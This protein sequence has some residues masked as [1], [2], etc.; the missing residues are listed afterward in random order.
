MSANQ[1]PSGG[2]VD[3][4]EAARELLGSGADAG[5]SAEELLL[6]LIE[7]HRAMRGEFEERFV[8]LGELTH[9]INNPLTSLI[10]R[11]QLIQL[12]PPGDESIRSGA[13]VVERS[14]TRVAEYVR[15][16][17][18]QVRDGRRRLG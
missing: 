1:Y 12:A 5:E 7:L 16:L 9:S 18:E 3:V 13:A 4:A 8:R 15:E 17:A 2:V 14:A 10:G 6:A 11:A